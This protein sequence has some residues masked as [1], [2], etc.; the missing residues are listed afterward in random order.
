[1]RTHLQ[2]YG[3]QPVPLGCCLVAQNAE[4]PTTPEAILRRATTIRYPLGAAGTGTIAPSLPNRQTQT[5]LLWI[6]IRKIHVF[7]RRLIKRVNASYPAAA[8]QA[9]TSKH[10]SVLCVMISKDGVVQNVHP[11]LLATTNPRRCRDRRAVA[12]RLTTG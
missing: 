7:S 4:S 5:M 8:R 12:L 2:T 10:G 6:A 1:M 9:H 11:L 3:D